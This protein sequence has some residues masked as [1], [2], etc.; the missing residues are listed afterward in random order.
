MLYLASIHF[1][2]RRPSPITTS[3]VSHVTVDCS[4]CWTKKKRSQLILVWSVIPHRDH[5]KITLKRSWVSELEHWKTLAQS[6]ILIGALCLVCII[7]QIYWNL[8]KVTSEKCSILRILQY[9]YFTGVLL[10]RAK[11]IFTTLLAN[12][13][14]RLSEADSVTKK[15]SFFDFRLR[16]TL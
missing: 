16:V 9:S 5:A 7:V 1:Y 13:V 10:P 11:I 12:N 6:V 2:D 4:N 14:G 15:W 3:K 8:Q